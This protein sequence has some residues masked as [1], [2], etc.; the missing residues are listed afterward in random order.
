[1][2]RGTNTIEGWEW[3]CIHLYGMKAKKNK[4]QDTSVIQ[5][6]NSLEMHPN[7]NRKRNG[8]IFLYA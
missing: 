2:G 7:K 5:M 8:Q 6:K 1:M 3:N 4:Q